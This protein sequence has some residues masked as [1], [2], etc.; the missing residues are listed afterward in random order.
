MSVR[1]PK[2]R[3]VVELEGIRR[4]IAERMSYSNREI[5]AAYLTMD[6]SMSEV[7]KARESRADKPSLNA[8]IVK[9]AAVAL[10]SHPYVNAILEEEKIYLAAEANVCVAVDTPRGLFAPVVGQA[11][12]K[13]V[14]QISLEISRLAEQA[15]DGTIGLYDLTGGTFTVSNLGSLGVEFFVPIINPPQT[16]IL[17]VGR[18]REDGRAYLT[19]SMDHRAFDGAE[20]ARFLVDLRKELEEKAASYD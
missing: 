2:I 19:L 17:G 15:R 8:Y 20:G 6:V 1:Q 3:Q 4:T 5:P 7:M 16:A 9:A 12:S 18:I 13:K 11:D 10:M 14:G